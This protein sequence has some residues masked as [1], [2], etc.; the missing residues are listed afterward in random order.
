MQ[1]LLETCERENP[2]PVMWGAH[3]IEHGSAVQSTIAL[4]SGES[5]H[6]ALLRSSAHALGIRVLLNDWHH[7]VECEIHIRCDCSVCKEHVCSRRTGENST[8]RCALLVVTTS[9]TGRTFEGAQCPD[10]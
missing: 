3:F 2:D 7:G 9:S 6:C 10:K 5:E 8:C 4:S 1:T